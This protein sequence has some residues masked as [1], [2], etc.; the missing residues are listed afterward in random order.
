MERSIS[1]SRFASVYS[2]AFF[3]AAALGIVML[4][5]DKNLQTDFGAV[6]SGY[7]A[8]WYGVLALVVVT[9]IGAALLVAIRSRNVVKL[10]IAGSGVSIVALLGIVLTYQQVGFSSA[11]A[12]AQYLFGIT[13]YGGDV[14]YL[15]DALLA[16][17]IVA[18]VGGLVGLLLTREAQAPAGPTEGAKPGP[19]Q[20]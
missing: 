12:F 15:Y 3:I 9:L 5:T 17:Y 8:H 18:F 7:Y 20:A 14:R 13:D 16:V 19:N 11:M 10:A 4:I 6:S 1:T 2:L